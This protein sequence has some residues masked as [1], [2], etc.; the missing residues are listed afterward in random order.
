MIG[1]RRARGAKFM[2]HLLRT[3]FAAA[4][5]LAAA[6]VLSAEP[7][8]DEP[9][10]VPKNIKQGIDFVYVDPGMS[11]VA[12]RH[13]KPRNWLARIFKG[14]NRSTPN[15][16]FQRLADGLDQYEAS[17]GRLPQAKIPAGPALKLGSTG[18]RVAALRTR[19]GLPPG[20]GF[21]QQLLQRVT[22][23]QQVHGLAPVDG[24]VGKGTLSS[25]NRG[26]DYY[27][28]VIAI[29]MERAWR[30]PATRAFERY[31]VID[32][33]A[34]MAYLFDRDRIADSMRVVVGAAKTKTPMMAV[35]MQDAKANPYWNVPPE[36]IRSLTA[37]RIGE[38]GLSYLD[39]FHY[40]V[41]ANWSPSAPVIDP[42]GVNWK[43]IARSKT[44]AEIRVRQ[45]PGP[46]NSM[47]EMK[48]EMPN[49][50]GIY[51]HDTPHKELFAK[52]ERH[53]SNGCVRLA[54]YRRFASWVFGRMPQ[55]TSTREQ[56]FPLPRPLPVYMTYLT[57]EATPNG[58]MFRPD[59]YGF[60]GLAMPQMF[61]RARDIAAA[62]DGD[63][64][65]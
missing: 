18:K 62:A 55:V 1:E 17:W 51:L 60:D 13:Q 50:Y 6:P 40:E 2:R 9:V 58:V 35:L 28:R 39:D 38:Q 61:G 4:V 47:G 3:A 52:D 30:L 23:Y 44:P 46:W 20:N 21:D 59:V 15:P 33:G 49:D 31:V 56:V 63:D 5:L 27:E 54:D 22:A 64:R 16:V 10:A 53:L 12:R 7:K 36:L 29:N 42:K 11:A 14:D 41:L 57:V 43:K 26:A 24:I 65:G 45:L 37:R 34:A 19:L 32:S 8:G 48:F 25:L